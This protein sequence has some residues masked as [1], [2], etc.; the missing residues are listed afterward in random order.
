M[1]VFRIMLA[2][3]CL[4]LLLGCAGENVKKGDADFPTANPQAKH[5]LQV[6]GTIDDGVPVRFASFWVAT[7]SKRWPVADGN[8]N[9]M[10]NR[11]EGVS[12]GY[13]VH[14]PITPKMENQ[15]YTFQVATDAFLPGRCGWQ[16][17]GVLIYTDGQVFD[18]AFSVDAAELLVAHNPSLPNWAGMKV[19]VE[20]HL[21]VTCGVNTYGISQAPHD[22]IFMQCQDAVSRKKVRAQLREDL[23]TP[24]NFELD[25]HRDR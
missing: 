22:G 21:D 7:N 9:Y 15:Q 17:S 6:H 24:I 12:D 1:K 2:L 20:P 8:C 11:L 13:S 10:F 5:F 18:N 4:N 16:F 3:A 19:T 25:I 23:A 14:I